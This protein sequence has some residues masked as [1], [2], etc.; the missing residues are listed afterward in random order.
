MAVVGDGTTVYPHVF[1]G[2]DAVLG[3]NCVLYPHVTVRERCEAGDRV[4]LHSG[5]VVGSD[6][7]GYSLVEGVHHKIPQVGIVVLGDD[8]EIGANT[9]IDRARFGKTVIV[10]TKIDN[11]VQ[12]AHNV[13]TGRC[14]IVAQVGV[15]GSTSIGNYVTLAGQSAINGHITIGDQAIVTA[16][17]GVE[18]SA[19]QA[20]VVGIPAQPM[21]NYQA[22]EI[23]VRRLPCKIRLK[24]CRRK[25]PSSK[26]AWTIRVDA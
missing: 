2:A 4:I 1:V 3:K 13:S 18:I 10:R 23:A 25:L 11:L 6:G 21:R 12:I 9:S 24:I 19:S 7:F 5:C 26:V 8:V 22:Q 17:A 16:R 15:A 14:I 20:A